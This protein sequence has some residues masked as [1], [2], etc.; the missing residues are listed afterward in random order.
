VIQSSFTKLILV[1]K[2][3]VKKSYIEFNE[4][5]T[6][7]LVADT[8]L[9]TDR[10]AGRQAGRRTDGQADGPAGRQADGRMDV[11]PTW[12]TFTS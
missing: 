1:Q 3:F 9:Q 7:S 10:Q 5:L 6:N 12:G 8:R 2:I 11:V 4:N